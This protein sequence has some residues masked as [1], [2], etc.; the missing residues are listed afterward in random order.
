MGHDQRNSL[1]G[2]L[3]SF[4]CLV[5][6]PLPLCAFEKEKY[7]GHGSSCV[8]QLSLFLLKYPPFRRVHKLLFL[9]YFPRECAK[10]LQSIVRIDSWGTVFVA[11]AQLCC[12]SLLSQ[13]C[14][15]TPYRNPFRNDH[16]VIAPN[17][18]RT[19]HFLPDCAKLA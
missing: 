7:F 14:C 5:A 16:S 4:I 1:L 17:Y 13:R 19:K 18:I 9:N 12:S 15:S 2:Q 10:L 6:L 11:I 3:R 8:L